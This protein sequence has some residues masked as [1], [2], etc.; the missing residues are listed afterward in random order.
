[1]MANQPL[2]GGGHDGAGWGVLVGRGVSLGRGELMGGGSVAV[3][4]TNVGTDK[5][6]CVLVAVGRKFVSVETFSD[7]DNE[8]PPKTEVMEMTA[9]IMAFQNWRAGGII[10]FLWLW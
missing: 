5:I 3:M 9:R 4:V 8:M 6:L 7:S 2:G 10:S 1:M